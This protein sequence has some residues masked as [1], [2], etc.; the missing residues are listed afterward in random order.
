MELAI[1]IPVYNEEKTIEVL[2]RDL[3][4]LVTTENINC[5]FLIINDGSTD[6]TLAALNALTKEI[7][8]LKIISQTNSGHGPSLLKGYSLAIK[9]EWIFQLDS[10]YEYDLSAFKHLWQNR[11]GFDLLIAEREKRNASF[12]R[13]V[14]TAISFYAVSLLYGTGIKDINCPYRLIRSEKLSLALPLLHP[15]CF[16][17]NVLFT[18]FFFNKYFE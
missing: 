18:A 5:Q 6:N 10:D 4:R 11:S 15:G 17:P 8:T 9:H 2:I 12:L 14:A 13:D 3:F 16:A 1:V 7:P